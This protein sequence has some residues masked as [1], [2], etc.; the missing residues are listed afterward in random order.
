VKIASTKREVTYTLEFNEDELEKLQALVDFPNWFRQ[1]MEY[2]EF[3]VELYDLIEAHGLSARAA[4]AGL[5][6]YTTV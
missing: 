4:D 3:F 1:P 5:K 2:Q 6:N